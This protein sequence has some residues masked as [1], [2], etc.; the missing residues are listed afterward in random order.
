MVAALDALNLRV[1][2]S[3]DNLSGERLTR[4]LQAINASPHKDRFRVLAGIDF[5]NVGPGWG[6]KAVAA[7]RSRH[8]GR[9]HRRR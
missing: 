5:R 8:Q 3:A 9:R 4:A 6:E 2:V 7:A 1:M